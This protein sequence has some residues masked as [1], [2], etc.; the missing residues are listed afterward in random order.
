MK[1][2]FDILD[3][4]SRK[5][6]RT[7]TPRVSSS[8]LPAIISL[9]LSKRDLRDLRLTSRTLGA[10]VLLRLDRVFI[11]PNPPNV[12]VFR[13]IADHEDY[14]YKVEEIICDDTQLLRDVELSDRQ[15]HEVEERRYDWEDIFQCST[16]GIPVWYAYLC[17]WDRIYPILGSLT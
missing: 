10:K 6:L 2:I 11:S 14:R 17:Y 15:I 1:K 4:F 16:Y 9:D 5:V 7:L 13:T 12:E 3:G 8:E